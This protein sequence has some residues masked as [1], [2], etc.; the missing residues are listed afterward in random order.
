MIDA[1]NHL[2]LSHAAWDSQAPEPLAID[3]IVNRLR[4]GR[5]SA[6]GMVVGGDQAF[7]STSAHSRWEGT[8]RALAQY[9]GG[10]ANSP[11]SITTIRS[12]ADLDALTESK[13]GFLLCLEG[14]NVC[15]DSPFEDPLAALRLLTQLGIRS[16]QVMAAPQTPLLTDPSDGTRH[17]TDVGREMIS[18]ANRLNLIVDISHLSGDEPAF[19]E[20]LECSTAPPIASHHSCRSITGKDQALSDEAIHALASLGGVIGIHTGSHWLNNEHRQATVDDFLKHITRVVDLV[21]IDHVGIGTDHVDVGA[22]PRD[23]PDGMF[24]FGFDGP[25]DAELIASA[26]AD[27]GYTAQ[28]CEKILS[29]NV[30]R[31]W[32]EALEERE[33]A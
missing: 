17:L 1:H 13:P 12:K 10:I 14:M 26:L 4:Q 28:D 20:I 3:A 18:E 23:L 24:M 29:A 16:I 30:R 8:L 21:G 15:F 33:I 5:I 7:P 31:V 11:G 32:R 22:L 2:L 9:W 27:D 25:E 19:L 6:V